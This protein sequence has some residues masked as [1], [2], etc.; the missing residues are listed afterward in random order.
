MSRKEYRKEFRCTF[1]EAKEIAEAAE[2]MKMTESAY[3]RYRVLKKEKLQRLP[4]E[5]ED[6]LKE[7]K[8]QTLKIGTNI[9]Q[10]VR[11]C[12]SKKFITKEDYR[13]LVDYLVRL[14]EKYS[15]MVSILKEKNNG[16]HEASQN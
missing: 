10:V 2:K 15:D 9:N 4:G 12:N 5:I 8:Y 3:M 1:E 11:S 7:L 13:K 6:Q 14:D 16:D